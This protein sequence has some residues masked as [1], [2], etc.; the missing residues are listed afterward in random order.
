MPDTRSTPV[1]PTAPTAT[2]PLVWVAFVLF[3]LAFAFATAW[4]FLTAWQVRYAPAYLASHAWVLE[5]PA[6]GAL[7]GPNRYTENDTFPKGGAESEADGSAARFEHKLVGDT[8]KAK[9]S[10]ILEKRA[11]EW[12]VV[13]AAWDEEGSWMELKVD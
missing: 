3:T 1:T 4:P 9:V 10:T 6:I 7:V 8:R 13:R 5:S 11:G 12:T 2:R